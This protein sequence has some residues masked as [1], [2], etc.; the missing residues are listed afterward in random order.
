MIAG[1]W[2]NNQYIAREPVVHED[3]FMTTCYALPGYYLMLEGSATSASN[4]EWFVSEFFQAERENAARQGSSVYELCNRLV[5]ATKPEDSTAVFLPFLYGCN[6]S[7]DGK[8]CLLGFDGWHSRG[9]VL[10][11]V[12]EGVIFSHNWHLQRLLQFRPK[13][14]T[15]RLSGGAARSDVWLQMF[16]DILQIPVEV[17]AGTELGAMG[18]ALVAAVAVGLYGSYEEAV[19][20]MVSVERAREPDPQLAERYRAKYAR[21]QRALECMEPFWSQAAGR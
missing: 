15:V 3:V 10:R 8:A 7:L 5:A 20:A 21:Y 4:L 11:A 12:Y 19:A 16:A 18:A 17:P 2:G 6:V 13:P 9:H 14:Q 1:T